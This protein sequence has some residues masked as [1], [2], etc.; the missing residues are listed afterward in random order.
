M[1]FE[2]I[3][4]AFLALGISLASFFFHELGHIFMAWRLQRPSELTLKAYSIELDFSTEGLTPEEIKSVY[5]SG[6]IAGVYPL[7][8]FF[9]IPNV[10]LAVLLFLGGFLLHLNTTI[11]DLK[12]IRKL[13]GDNLNAILLFMT[14]LGMFLSLF[15]VVALGAFVV[16]P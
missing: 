3:D 9:F 13:P 2:P 10:M 15:G 8:L 4:V 12:Q 5:W 7:F 6:V 14:P 1:N 16:L 11:Y